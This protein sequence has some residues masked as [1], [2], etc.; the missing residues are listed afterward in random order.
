MSEDAIVKDKIID[1][2]RDFKKACI[3]SSN[4]IDASEPDIKK[5]LEQ[6]FTEETFNRLSQLLVQVFSLMEELDAL[7]GR[8]L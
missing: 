2:F 1:A 8:G 5:Q 7:E 6:A 3:D 4:G